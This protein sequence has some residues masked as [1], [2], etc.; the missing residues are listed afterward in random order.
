MRGGLERTT[1]EPDDDRVRLRHRGR[2]RGQ[3]G[4]R[5]LGRRGRH[6]LGRGRRGRARREC[7]RRWI[8]LD[9]SRVGRLRRHDLLS[10]GRGR[11]DLR[12]LR[13]VVPGSRLVHEARGLRKPRRVLS[14]RL[15]RRM[16]L[17]LSTNPAALSSIG[18]HDRP[19]LMIRALLFQDV[20]VTSLARGRG[21]AASNANTLQDHAP[22]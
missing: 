19:Q 6:E 8:G 4:H 20:R 16:R 2:R 3:L 14:A 13:V 12:R 9:L 5:H 21:F 7:G 22:R 1:P 17:R 18:E 11:R 15:L 10:D